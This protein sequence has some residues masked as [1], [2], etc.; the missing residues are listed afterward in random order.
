MDRGSRGSVI[1]AYCWGTIDPK[2]DAKQGRYFV[3]MADGSFL[4]LDCYEEKEALRNAESKNG[5]AV[6]NR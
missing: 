4:H 5:Y 2:N 6:F 1:C 3:A